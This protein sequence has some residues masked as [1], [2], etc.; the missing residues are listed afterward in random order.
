MNEMTVES[1]WCDGQIE[2]LN[3]MNTSMDYVTT[4]KAWRKMIKLAAICNKAILQKNEESISLR[5]CPQE[6]S[7]TK[8]DDIDF[9]TPGLSN[10][11]EN[12][13]YEDFGSIF[14]NR[15]EIEILQKSKEILDKSDQKKEKLKKERRNLQKISISD[16]VGE[17]LEKAL[18]FFSHCFRD[19]RAL[20]QKNEKIYE[21]PF[22]SVNKFQF[23]AHKKKNGRIL[24]VIK[25][26]PEIV[27]KKSSGYYKN[28]EIH[29]IDQS[30]KE[31]FNKAYE[32]FGSKGE[33]VIG[34]AFLEFDDGFKV[35]Q[36]KKMGTNFSFGK[37]LFFLHLSQSFLN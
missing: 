35:D 14:S 36:L 37:I 1:I 2:T 20:R 10:L 19:S 31:E 13:D 15:K 30:F 25:G 23:S 9:A 12:R 7:C 6:T 34:C 33:R 21:L 3:F 16:L 24:G 18:L 32:H 11:K 28:G 27:L 8:R 29:K 4:S 26:A 22:N 5:T 17:P